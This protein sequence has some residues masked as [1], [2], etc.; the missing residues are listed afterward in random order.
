MLPMPLTKR[1]PSK[2][3]RKNLFRRVIVLSEKKHYNNAKRKFT[4]EEYNE[5]YGIEE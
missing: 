2:G 5:I 3:E 4:Q 1:H